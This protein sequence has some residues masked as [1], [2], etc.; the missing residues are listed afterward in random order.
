MKF[1][2][3]MRKYVFFSANTYEEAEDHINKVAADQDDD[4]FVSLNQLDDEAFDPAN[5]VVH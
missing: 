1:M 4:T 5:P 2:I 3:D